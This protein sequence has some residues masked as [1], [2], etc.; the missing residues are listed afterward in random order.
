[1]NRPSRTLWVILSILCQ[2]NSSFQEHFLVPNIGWV[3]LGAQ[4]LFKISTRCKI[5]NKIVKKYPIITCILH[6]YL[7]NFNNFKQK[8]TEWQNSKVGHEVLKCT[9]E[10]IL[11][12][13]GSLIF[14]GSRKFGSICSGEEITIVNNKCI[15]FKE[16]KYT[17]KVTRFIRYAL[18]KYKSS[19]NILCDGWD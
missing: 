5:F 11:W 15:S 19:K 18:T 2:F 14:L 16:A 7:Q 8:I 9:I 3:K 1:M 13:F 12:G 17:V 6:D 4:S 10:S